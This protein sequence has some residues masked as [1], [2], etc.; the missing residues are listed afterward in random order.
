MQPKRNLLTIVTKHSS[1]NK[2]ITS[3]RETDIGTVQTKK[4]QI[5][6]ICCR[7]L[8]NIEIKGNN[9]GKQIDFQESNKVT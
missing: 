2:S 4:S 9:V 8:E 6:I 5:Y 7:M 1:A 3:F